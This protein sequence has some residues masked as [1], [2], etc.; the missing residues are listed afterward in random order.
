MGM[1]LSIVEKDGSTP[2]MD[3]KLDA[4]RY[5]ARLRAQGRETCLTVE[6]GTFAVASAGLVTLKFVPINWSA[7]R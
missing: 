1:T 5:L 2:S 3:P 7:K 6:D 4:Y